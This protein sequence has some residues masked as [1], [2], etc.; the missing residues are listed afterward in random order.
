MRFASLPS[1]GCFIEAG[2]VSPA[3]LNDSYGGALLGGFVLSQDSDRQCT[4]GFGSAHF[5]QT[6]EG[7]FCSICGGRVAPADS[8]RV[9]GVWRTRYILLV[10]H[11]EAFRVKLSDWL[12]AEGHQIVA[13]GDGYAAVGELGKLFKSQTSFDLILLDRNL[14]GLDVVQVLRL[15]RSMDDK[16]PIFVLADQSPPPALMLQLK[17]YRANRLVVR[18]NPERLQETIVKHL[19]EMG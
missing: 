14:G 18:S 19:E 10:D 4:C 6:P 3:G 15:M 17:Q 12:S 7:L 1:T 5:T 9:S 16:V 13:V 11:D 2:K 8:G